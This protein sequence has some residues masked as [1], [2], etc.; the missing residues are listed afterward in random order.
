[1][2]G[3]FHTQLLYQDPETQKI[4]GPEKIEFLWVRWFGHDLPYHRGWVA[5]RLHC[6]GFIP[7]VDDPDMPEPFSFLD[8]KDV[9]RGIHLIPAFAHGH[10][11][12][13]LTPSIVHQ[14]EENNEDW[15]Y[16][17]VNMYITKFLLRKQ[18]TNHSS[19]FVDQDMVM[20]YLGGGIGHRAIWDRSSR[21]QQ[22]G[23][24][25]N[26]G[27][28]IPEDLQD[29]GGSNDDLEAENVIGDDV[30]EEADGEHGDTVS[31][32]KSERYWSTQS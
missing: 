13:L 5:K 32:L 18:S 8:P 19:R 10:T 22:D 29:A 6:I 4:H 25:E 2:I 26:Q 27:D 15:L 3:I 17:Y 16:Y 9:I 28:D 7:D 11:A 20:R 21:T 12:D 14:P 31:G 23:S 30:L 1:M 24:G